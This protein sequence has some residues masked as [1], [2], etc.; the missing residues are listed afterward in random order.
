MAQWVQRNLTH[1]QE[2]GYGLF[3]VLLKSRDLVIGDCG[4]EQ[5][6]AADGHAAELGYDF[7][8]DYWHQGYATEAASAIRDY[9][10]QQ[11]QL[12]R[13]ISL[14]RQNNRASQRVAEKIGMRRV[15][16]LVR[17]DT[18]YWL[19]ELTHELPR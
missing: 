19:Y 1:Q 15:K 9:A 6:E 12:P 14:I 8:S 17:D 7:R 4:L 5:I 16:Q 11:V 2:Y 10:F 13:L 3:S 18:S